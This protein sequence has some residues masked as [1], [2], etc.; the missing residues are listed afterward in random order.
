MSE[1]KLIRPSIEE[2][3]SLLRVERLPHIWCPSCGIG[4]V[5]KAYVEA[6]LRSGIPPE[7]HVLVSG[8]GCSSR[9][10]GYIKIDG[11]HVIHGRAIPFAVGLKTVR[12]ELEVTVFA[13]DGDL[14][15]IGGNH[16]IH[17]IRRNDDIN[18][19]MINNFTYG[20]TGGQ[21]GGT[22]PEGSRTL[23]SPYGHIEGTFN[24]PLLVASIGAPYVARWTVLHYRQ[25][26]DT[27][28]EM[29][30]VDGFAFLEVISPCIIYT[31]M[32]RRDAIGLMRM[33]KHQSE[34]DHTAD[35]RNVGI[36]HLNEETR[37]IVGKFVHRPSESYQ[38]KYRK[39][40]ER[41]M[42]GGE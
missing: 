16:L 4:I 15:T 11:Y 27:I 35:L 28:V 2:I 8:I 7:K 18:V 19:I 42:K 20:M 23:T 5:A 24:V 10:P 40:V 29:F 26:V 13:G 1:A 21:Y 32:N 22:T 14:S 6:L 36:E 31:D 12:P 37:F 38:T 17:A 9:M 25:I 39:L 30:K 33:F 41:V 34:I 3:K